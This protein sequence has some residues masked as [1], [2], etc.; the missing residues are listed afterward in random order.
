MLNIF[1]DYIK[2]IVYTI[3]C[4]DKYAMIILEQIKILC[5]RCNLGRADVVFECSFVMIKETRFDEY[6]KNNGV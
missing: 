5:V 3:Y 6:R 4:M 1:I 2:E